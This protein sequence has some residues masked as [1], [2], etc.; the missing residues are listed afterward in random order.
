MS[1]DYFARLEVPILNNEYSVIV[2]VGDY[3]RAYALAKK[4]FSNP[5]DQENI[6][7][8]IWRE[9]WI[10]P[11]IWVD[12][13]FHTINEHHFYAT[14]AHEAVHAV[15]FIFSELGETGADEVF[16]HSVAA[17]VAAVERH[18]CK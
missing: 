3:D 9:R 6:R 16:A 5:V 17:I 14:L 2:A 18:I 8:C 7:G 12:C 10:K 13:G 1:N 11:L 15:Q 4:M